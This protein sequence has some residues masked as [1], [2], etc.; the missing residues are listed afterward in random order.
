MPCI[1]L[2][3][4]IAAQK[5]P[6]PFSGVIS[7]TRPGMRL[8]GCF[9]HAIRAL[10][11]PNTADTRF[12]MASGCKVFTAVAVSQLMEQGRVTEHTRLL[13]CVDA[14]LPHIDP[15]VTLHQRLTH[16]SGMPDYFDEAV[17][18]D[19][20]D[21]WRDRPMYQIQQPRDF[22]PLFNHLPMV[23]SPGERFAYNISGFIL[24]GLV[25]EALTGQSFASYVRQHVFT[26][27]GMTDS[28]YFRADDLPDR[29]AYAYLQRPDGSWSTNIFSVPVMGGPDG[30][31]YTTAPD[32]ERFWKALSDGTR[33]SPEW[34]LQLRVATGR[35]RPH[36]HYGYGV[37]IEES[38]SER[39]FFVEGSDPGVVLRSWFVPDSQTVL[40]VMGN[41]GGAAWHFLIP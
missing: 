41:T 28:G 11:L 31:A 17:M 6:E 35:D 27:A 33:L 3:D 8:E 20:A 24:L 4:W 9:G 1:D 32:M 40:T 22:L 2:T 25:V 12:Q 29:T 10:E 21:V 37:W 30:G 36:T 16:T 7:L 19:Y 23:F 14:D 39:A 38:G 34:I 13:D 5:L 15:R 26:P 18:H